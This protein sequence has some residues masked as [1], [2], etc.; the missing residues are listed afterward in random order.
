[1][2]AS[3]IIPNWNGKVFLKRCLSSLTTQT[4][5]DFEVVVVDNGSIDGSIEYIRKFFTK[6]KVIP[7]DKNYGFARAVNV[8]IKSS[9]AEYI[10]LIN[11]DTEVDKDC[12]KFLVN[13]A[14]K[15][16]EVGFV[17]AKMLNFYRREYI[18]SAGDYIDEHGHADNIGYGEKDGVFFSSAKPV[19]LATGGG[20][21]FKREV[22]EKIGYFDED[23][24]MYFEDVDLCL[25][26][27][28]SG[29]KGYFEPK[30]KIYHIHKGSA[31]R[32]SSLVE[33]LQFRNMTVTVL[34]DFPKSLFLTRLIWLRIFWVNINT[35]RFMA[36]QGY[37]KEALKAEVY[38]LSHLF[39][40]LQ[41]RR[42]VQSGR[43]ASDE[44]IIQNIRRRKLTFFGL[45]G[46]GI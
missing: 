46:N 6:V 37:L 21:L 26:A 13:R 11:N 8:G 40:I 19:F 22:F 10:V 44:Y 39:S 32:V 29:F 1:M 41:K 9:R 5:K 33:Y 25:R 17:A 7:L 34:K 2:K 38:V 31:R 28:L 3:V 23:Y 12:L 27:Q 24:F 20:S 30:A 43:T 18:D 15:H 36:G 4:L 45:F 42:L 35:I 16:S 14:R